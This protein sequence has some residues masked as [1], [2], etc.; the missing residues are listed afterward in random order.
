M[1]VVASTTAFL[2]VVSTVAGVHHVNRDTSQQVLKPPVPEPIV[3]TELPLP[4]VAD[5]KEGSCTPKISPHRTGC[6]LKSSQI[7]SGNFLPDNN[8]VLVSLNFSGA[9]A[10]P[11]PASIYNGTHLTLIKADGTNFPSGDPW[12]CIT[13]GVPEENKVGSTELSPYPQAFLD[14][15]RALIGTN[16]VDCGSALLASS[17][18]TPDKVHIYPVR[19]NVKADGSGSG[20]NIRELRLHQDNV[21]LGFNS[22]TFSNGQLGQFGYFS[23]LQFNPSPKT[24]E[25]RSARYDLVNVTRLYNPESPQ[26]ISAKGNQ[27]SFNRS[28]IAVGEL[29]GFTG[30]GKE[31]TYIG[32]PVESCNIDVFAADLTTG[33]VRRVTDHPEYVDPIDV[34]PDDKWQ[35]ILDTR[36]TGRQ[37]FMAGMRGI[38]PI[39]D[40]IATTVASSTRN[41][42][43]RRFFRPW[44]LDH[45]GDRGDYYGQQING[46]GDGSPGSINDPNW[47]AGADPKWS[48]D[49][50]RIAYFENL[51]VSPSCGG[52]NP[53]PCPNSTEP[54]GR[55]TRLMLAHLTSREPLDLEPVAPVSDEVPW[56]V[57]YVPESALPDRP[58]PAEGNYTLKGEVSGSASVSIIHDK[59]IPAAIKTIAVT[60]RNYSDDGLHFIAGSERFTNTVASMTI[61]KVDW[62]SDLTST[63]QITGSKKTSPGGFHLEIDA[64]TNI[65]NA[66]GTLTTT[67]DGKVWK[68]PANG[69]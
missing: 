54:G 66:N 45:D 47:N 17:D 59:T 61:N 24:G 22:F 41:N 40:L 35:V 11:D 56:G 26:P 5:N 50:T 49:G 32:N 30:R 64:M 15:K 69:T 13:C 42:G 58:F 31:V 57:P 7:Q 33:K 2:G 67:I 36:G 38:P 28:A 10:A 18:C 51:V 65:F 21:H 8:H 52:Q 37:M 4:P 29:R 9:P 34:S 44:L 46:D 48:H 62:F 68:Q 27:L 39:I 55:V 6:L 1:H 63:G 19:W 14:G 16:I 20:G 25:P 3:V 23:R 43:P 53:L 12:K 60:Y